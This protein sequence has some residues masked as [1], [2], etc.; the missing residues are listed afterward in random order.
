[1]QKGF[2]L[3][4]HVHFLHRLVT[5]LD[6][7]KRQ[8]W[9][10]PWRFHASILLFT[11][12]L[13][14]LLLSFQA[15]RLDKVNLSVGESRLRL[16]RR[17]GRRWRWGLLGTGTRREVNFLIDVHLLD[18]RAGAGG[19]QIERRIMNLMFGGHWGWARCHMDVR[20]DWFR[21]WGA[22]VAERLRRRTL[23]SNVAQGRGWWWGRA[24]GQA[25]AVG[26]AGPVR[27]EAG[28]AL[29]DLLAVDRVGSR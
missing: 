1:M 10:F 6:F 27:E 7:D 11:T 9:V 25:F 3:R 20:R 23:T 28:G 12:W 8:F 18:L 24:E 15:F 19:R 5:W 13:I 29:H 16:L 21:S 22:H 26:R 4:L 17:G 14:L 2:R